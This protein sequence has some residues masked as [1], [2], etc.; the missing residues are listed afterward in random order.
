[1][2]IT[3]LYPN[4]L[5]YNGLYADP[6]KV[7]EHYRATQE[8]DKWFIYGD[9]T[10]LTN[11]DYTFS[12]FPDEDEWKAVAVDSDEGMSEAYLAVLDAFYKATSHYKNNFFDEET[13][14]W[15]FTAPALCMYKT[16]GGADTD[17]GMFFH[18]DFQQERAD[19]PGNKPVLTCTMYLND[20]YEGGEIKF[21]VI[22]DNGVDYDYF[23]YKPKAG[24][25]LVFP[26]RAPYYHGVNKT[27]KG[28]KYFVRTFWQ[29][30]HPGAP[31]WLEN[32]KKYGSEQ[33]A[34]MEKERERVERN[35][36]RYNLK[37]IDH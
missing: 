16:D 24:D 6:Q 19:A 28:Q 1:M 30:V 32:Q 8:W 11:K 21:K 18:T 15:K 17:V 2:Q 36:G 23:D 33:W 4:V 20:D 25:V 13:P 9:I 34:E 10:V 31:E 22:K 14:N 27:T 7:I 12:E 29:Y 37:G 26:S 5:V 3:E 35:S